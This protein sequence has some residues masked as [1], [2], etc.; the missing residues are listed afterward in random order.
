M[1]LMRKPS[2]LFVPLFTIYGR[3]DAAAWVA[4]AEDVLG[5]WKS[6]AHPLAKITNARTCKKD[7]S[8][9]KVKLWD[10]TLCK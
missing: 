10:Y 2:T 5:H 4:K 8:W 3:S 1:H 6:A 7:P 9:A